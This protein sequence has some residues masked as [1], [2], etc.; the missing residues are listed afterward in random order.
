MFAVK[1]R[2][3][4]N[5]LLGLVI[6]ARL[7]EM[8]E[9]QD[10]LQQL[11]GEAEQQ[12]VLLRVAQETID[13]LGIRLDEVPKSRRPRY[14]PEQRYRSLRVRDL[15]AFTRKETTQTFR[16]SES[17]I[18]TWQSESKADPKKTTIGSLA[19]PTPPVRR[20]SDVVRSLVQTMGVVGFGEHEMIA[21]VLARAGWR[22]SKTTV[23]RIRKEKR[24]KA[25]PPSKREP[26]PKPETSARAVR[27]RHVNHVLMMDITDLSSMFRLAVFKLVLAIDVFSRMPVASRVTR[28]E[29]TAEV[30]MEVFQA[31]VEKRGAAPHL[32]T[33]QGSQF[34][35]EGFKKMV[36]DGGTKQR[37]G[38]IGK[39]G[40][41]ALVE[42]TFRSLKELLRRLA[43]KPSTL[44]EAERWVGLNLL[45]YA[46]CRPHRGLGGATPAEVHFG[47]N[48]AHLSSLPPPR[49]RRGEHAGAAPFE[50]AYL[51][52]D[53][54]LPLLL[55]KAA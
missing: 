43:R 23:G 5:H 13:L 42:R 53:Q 36:K 47:L 16:V 1:A 33:D 41:I 30:V 46:Y 6:G 40:S 9:S 14:S 35:D 24:V 3:K 18:T 10:K 15:L 48:P 28:Q 12:A 52:E 38:A 19:K 32:V 7:A 54:R 44:E 27:A 45:H 11:F 21:G 39:S 51:D 34:I 17:T 8:R 49:G 22:M 20:Y 29:P 31:A 25:P 55:R 37:F 2:T 50:V 4:A 26:E